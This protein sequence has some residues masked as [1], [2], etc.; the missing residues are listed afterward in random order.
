LFYTEV[1]VSGT[2]PLYVADVSDC[3]EFTVVA[4]FVVKVI[5]TEFFLIEWKVE[6]PRKCD[7]V[8]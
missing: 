2:K 5:F 6:F 7:C 4:V 8:S 3:G 1:K